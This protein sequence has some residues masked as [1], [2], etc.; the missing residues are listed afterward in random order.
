MKSLRWL[1]RSRK[2]SY[3]ETSIRTI[4]KVNRKNKMIGHGKMIKI[5]TAIK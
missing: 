2:L 4:K 5:D 1:I 3:T